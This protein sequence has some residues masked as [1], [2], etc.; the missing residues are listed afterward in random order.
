[1][2]R[3]E[4]DNLDPINVIPVVRKTHSNESQIQN[5]MLC[6]FTLIKTWHK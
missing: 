2:I 1:M 5:C 3:T 6:M 4:E